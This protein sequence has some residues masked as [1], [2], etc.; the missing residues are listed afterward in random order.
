[1]LVLVGRI[2]KF[3]VSL[4]DVPLPA[5]DQIKLG[6]WKVRNEGKPLFSDGTNLHPNQHLTGSFQLIF[7][8]HS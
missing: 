6:L 1:M 3:R 2:A 4:K 8:V 7:L 5:A